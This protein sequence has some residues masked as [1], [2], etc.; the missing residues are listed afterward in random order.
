LEK[1]TMTDKQ[2]GEAL[3]LYRGLA[4]ECRR[5]GNYRE[6]DLWEKEVAELERYRAEFRARNDHENDHE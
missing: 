4:E 2:I 1:E 6:A 3:S 5:E